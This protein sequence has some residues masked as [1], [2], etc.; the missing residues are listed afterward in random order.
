MFSKYFI[1][2]EQSLSIIEQFGEHMPGGF[3][4]YRADE[5]EE[6]LYANTAVCHIFGCESLEEFRDFTG[7]TFRGMIHPDDYERISSSIK[8]QVNESRSDLDH[9]EYRIIRKDGETRWIDDYGH[10]VESE[11][12]KGLYYVF[13]SDITDSHRQAESDKAMRIAVIEALTRVYDSVWLIND[14]ETQH[15]ELFR[16]D[17]QTEHLLPAH[18]AV[19]ITRFSDAFAFYS[20]LILEE[21]RQ[22]FLDAVT[23]ENIIKNTAEKL[24]YSIPFRRVFE[25]GIRYYRLEFARLELKNGKTGIVAGFKNV[26]EEV[27]KELQIQHSLSLRAAVIEALTRVYDSVW[28]IK[29]METQRFELYRIDEDLVHVMPARTAMKITRF[30]DAFAFYSNLIL[31]EDRQ[32]F[33]DAVTPENIIKNTADKLIYSVPFRR[34][35]ETGIRYYRVEFAIL[36]MENGETE[37]VCGFKDV[38]DEVRKDQQIHQALREAIDAANASNKAKSDFLSSMSHDMRTPMNGIIGMTAI[39]ANHLDDRERVADCLRK[40]TESSNHLLSLI[41]DVLDMNKIESG[42]IELQEEEFCLADLIDEMLTMTRPQ[43]QAHEH[44]FRVNIVNV[45]HEQVIG[46]HRR[47]LQVFVNIMSNAIKYT[48]NGGKISLS[49]RENPTRK[50]GHGYYQF[51]FEDNGFGMTE[52]FQKHLFEPFAR[53][54]DK[55]NAGIQ[56]TGLGM[57]IT[58]NIVRM[59]GGDI[60]VDSVYG[61]GSRFTVNVYL[62][63]QNKEDINYDNFVDL[64]VLIADDDPVC[65][66]STC[67]LLNDMGMNSEWVLSGKAA[68][69]RAKTRQEQNRDFFAY[70]IDWKLPDM[71]GIET[72][73]E[74]RKLVGD[75]PPIIIFSAY[76]WTEIEQEAREAGANLFISKPLFRTKLAA[77]FNTLTS[78]QS[79]EAGEDDSL[80]KLEEMDLSGRHILLAEDQEI[81]AEIAMDFLEMTGAGVDWA[82]DGEQAVKMLA[83]S[84]DGYYSLILMDIRMPNMNGYEAAKTIR[85]MDRQYA[86]NVPIVAMSANAFTEDVLNSKKAGMNEHITKPIDIDALIR[87]LSTYVK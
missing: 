55:Q 21:D 52:E 39:A 81:N 11:V 85:A 69:D 67:A 83:D 86:K 6:L 43:I 40:I 15:F 42:K 87:V 51:I 2:N 8:K 82:Q 29:D 19:S 62:K 36:D 33:L 70:M 72:V 4:I 75:E 10:Y 37:I 34:V 84:P 20:N 57:A 54:N 49:V 53:A 47:L 13:V 5:G 23:P 28:I 59:M 48:P 24:I 46:D 68:V 35:F 71:G 50:H 17:K 12:Y 27:R 18:T 74:I 64:R 61:E 22:Q 3:F 41:N 77:L 79:A 26:D 1:L 60:A 14:M 9:V 65:C 63:I 30:S 73:R 76:I 78:G 44:N 25:D 38:D 32:T 7:F 56:G 31:E 45:E 16:I 80:L 58:R 66:E